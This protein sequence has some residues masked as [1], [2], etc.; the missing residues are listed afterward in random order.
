[1]SGVYG[2][3]GQPLCGRVH[4]VMSVRRTSF[5][6]KARTFRCTSKAIALLERRDRSIPVRWRQFLLL[7]NQNSPQ[8]E[9][10]GHKL[11][12]QSQW[13]AMLDAGLI[14]PL[15][16]RH[17]SPALP[18][19]D[20]LAMTVVQTPVAAME[21]ATGLDIMAVQP[22]IAAGLPPIRPTEA[23]ASKASMDLATLQQLMLNSLRQSCGLLAAG[24][25]HEIERAQDRQA[26]QRCMP[27]WKTSLLESPTARPVLMDWIAQVIDGLLQA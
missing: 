2:D 17:H 7:L 10:I 26:L 3:A 15:A 6:T 1:M 25:A 18:L 12:D 21:Q 13:Q 14:E 9:T 23:P 22:A 11:L 27:R 5:D 16:E 19:P 4:A 8:F 24:L 20:P